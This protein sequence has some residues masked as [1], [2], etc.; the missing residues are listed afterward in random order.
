MDFATRNRYRQR[1]EELAR[2]AGLTEVDVAR[3][4]VEMAAAAPRRRRRRTG[5]VAASTAIPATT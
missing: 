5:D 2:G 3:S 4:A 1:V